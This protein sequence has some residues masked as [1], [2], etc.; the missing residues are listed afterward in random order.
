VDRSLSV[1]SV[2][3]CQVEVPTTGRSFVQMSSTYRGVIE[4]DLETSIMWR[5]MP[6]RAVEA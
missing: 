5:P 2:V 1:V 6:T 3:L 4:C